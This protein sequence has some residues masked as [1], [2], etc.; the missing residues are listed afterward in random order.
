MRTAP[1]IAEWIARHLPRGM[2]WHLV[3]PRVGRLISGLGRVMRRVE[4]AQAVIAAGRVPSQSTGDVLAWWEDALHLPDTDRP[5]PVSE[6][7][8]QAEVARVLGSGS[9]PTGAAYVAMAAVWSLV[10]SV[11]EPAGWPWHVW[12]L[13]PVE[14]V[15]AFRAGTSTAGEQLLVTSTTWDAVLRLCDRIRPA[16]IRLHTRE[17]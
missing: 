6:A 14:H 16:G 4:E 7:E 15:K 8:R 17:V 13:G 1:Q 5:L 10:A 11:W 12:L 3:D 9:Y 2:R